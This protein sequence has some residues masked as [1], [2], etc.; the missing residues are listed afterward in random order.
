MSRAKSTSCPKPTNNA[1]AERGQ[2]RVDQ[3][4]HA[5]L[6]CRQGVKR[7]LVSQVGYKLK[8]RANVVAGNIV[9]ALHI[10]EGHA[11]RKAFYDDGD[12]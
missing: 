8:G 5:A 7:F 9:L 11:T 1:T 12:G 6:G 2:I 10:L 4:S 3:E